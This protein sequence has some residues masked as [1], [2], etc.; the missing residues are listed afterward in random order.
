MTAK[1]AF[2]ITECKQCPFF[3]SNN[4]CM[5]V[6]VQI[7]NH[8][9]QGRQIPVWCPLPNHYAEEL[10]KCQLDADRYRYLR[11]RGFSWSIEGVS[12]APDFTGRQDYGI[13]VSSWGCRPSSDYEWDITIDKL[14]YDQPILPEDKS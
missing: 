2:I 9:V 4:L 6:N 8:E 7:P 11:A 5:K 12:G 10:K 3:G 13:S 1:I 14:R